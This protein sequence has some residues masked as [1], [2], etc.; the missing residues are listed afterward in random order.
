MDELNILET[1]GISVSIPETGDINIFGSI[2][3]FTGDCLATN[4]I[5]GLVEDFSHD[6]YCPHCYCTRDSIS[7]TFNENEFVSRGKIEHA[8]DLK[9]LE[10][11][12][13]SVLHIRGQKRD[14]VLNRSKYYHTSESRTID[15]M[16]ILPEGILMIVMSCVLFEFMHVRKKITLETLNA[17]LLNMFSVLEVEKGNTPA[18]LNDIKSPGLGLSP[19]LTANEC[20]S[21]FR[22]LTYILSDLV[23]DEDTDDHWKLLIQLQ[24]VT[25]IV[26]APKLTESLLNYFSE[27][28]TNHL[29]L[30]QKLYPDLPIKPKQHF[31]IHLPSVVRKNGPPTYSSCLKYEL[32]NSFYKRITHITCNFKNIAKTLAIRNQLVSLAYSVNRSRMRNKCEKTHKCEKILISNLPGSC[33]LSS[34]LNL[35]TNAVIRMSTKARIC[36]RRYSKGNVVILRKRPQNRVLEFGQIISVVWCDSEAYCK[37]LHGVCI[38]SLTGMNIRIMRFAHNVTF[39]CV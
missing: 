24:E 19:K 28:Y 39:Y 31:L 9:E 22:H 15:I 38:L 17:R 2:S 32:R 26:F 13:G 7:H 6:Y 29:K 10:E 12:E 36:G 11:A 18:Q 4:E 23:E 35:P 34:K 8:K 33:E 1:D 16:H 37:R 5:F 21:L 30:F 3:Q 14:S 20:L 27:V 25:D